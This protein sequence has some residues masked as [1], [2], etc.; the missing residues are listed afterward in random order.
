[1]I[2][3]LSVTVEGFVG[4]ADNENI[5]LSLLP[6]ED[7]KRKESEDRRRDQDQAKENPQMSGCKALKDAV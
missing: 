4:F 6:K 1:M 7:Q 2:S 5:G 3:I